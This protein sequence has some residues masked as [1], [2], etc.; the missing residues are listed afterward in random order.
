MRYIRDRCLC[1]I[2][3]VKRKRKK[4]A[5]E[6][7]KEKYEVKLLA[8][9]N[10]LIAARASAAGFAD[11]NY[12]TASLVSTSTDFHVDPQIAYTRSFVKVQIT[13]LRSKRTT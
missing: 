9:R 8:T 6:S 12:C 4:K 13:K 5:V 7:N 3:I 11:S 1:F 10:K 2:L